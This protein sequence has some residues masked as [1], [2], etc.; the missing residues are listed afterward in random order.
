[1]NKLTHK[2]ALQALLDGHTVYDAVLEKKY[3]LHDGYLYNIQDD[4]Y[5][6]LTDGEIDLSSLIILPKTVLINGVEVPEPLRTIPEYH[7]TIFRV[8][9]DC[10]E[11][12]SEGSWENFDWQLRELGKGLV[13]STKEAAIAHADAL[14]KPTIMEK[15]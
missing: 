9:I 2:E 6:F 13:H 11:L 5:Y 3:I 7:E 8:S 1:M 15:K 4:G 14:L 12:I 10:K